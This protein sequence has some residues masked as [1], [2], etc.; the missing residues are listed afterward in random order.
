MASQIETDAGTRHAPEIHSPALNLPPCAGDAT[1]FVARES[2]LADLRRLFARTGEGRGATAL[3]SGDTGIGKTRLALEAGKEAAAR[4][5]QVL[6]GRCY[7]ASEPPP[8]NVFVELIDAALEQAPSL[9]AF[10]DLI[11]A[12]GPELALLVPHLRHTFPEIPAAPELDPIETRRYLF[13]GFSEFVGRLAANRPLVLLLDD[14][15]WADEPTLDLLAHFRGRVDRLPI[16]M[17]AICRDLDPG[18]KSRL[19]A[20]QESWIRQGALPLRIAGLS[21]LGVAELLRSLSGQEAPSSLLRSVYEATRGNP[22]FVEEVFKDLRERKNV[23]DAYGRFLPE[24]GLSEPR[25]PENIRIV[26]TGRISRLSTDTRR[27]LIAAAIFGDTFSFT[28]L[29]ALQQFTSEQ[30]MTAVEE[31]QQAALMVTSSEDGDSMTFAHGLI[32]QTLLAELSSPRRERLHLTAAEALERTYAGSQDEHVSEIANHL[33]KAGAGQEK[34]LVPYLI[35]TGEQYLRLAGY[36]EAIRSLSNAMELNERHHTLT[37][38]QQLANARSLLGLAYMGVGDLG[39]SVRQYELSLDL[40]DYSIPSGRSAAI[41]GVIAQIGIQAARRWWPRV[42]SIDPRARE[43]T[44]LAAANYER[45]TQFSYHQND[46]VRSIFCLLRSLNLAEKTRLT[47]QT[48]RSLAGIPLAA[49]FMSMSGLAE[50]YMSLA[51][52]SKARTRKPQDHA[53]VD[54]YLGMY[55][56]GSGRDWDEAVELFKEASELFSRVGDR[57]RHLESL[58]LLSIA[59]LHSGRLSQAM[60]TRKQVFELA[61]QQGDLQM[62]AMALIELAEAAMRYSQ[63]R[64]A[65]ELLEQ[66]R[67]LEQHTGSVDRIWMYGMLAAARV[68]TGDPKAAAEAAA[69]GWKYLSPSHPPAFYIL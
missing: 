52:A 30:L 68:R 35:K 49:G 48:A 17:I 3:I 4:G 31:A 37:D 26:L 41:V 42:N 23:I 9:P 2:E 44:E 14:L 10:A 6:V 38:R 8:Y 59:M 50:R 7:D 13:D 47:G 51:L 46:P 67:A 19:L 63:I 29:E 20:T 64:R 69:T 66:A 11:G 34:R 39:E 61:C 24:A 56:A 36:S 5:A 12:N 22:F 25:L 21:Q 57:R 65:L 43:I 27:V 40:I 58:S 60:E 53:F 54:E 16:L 62:K 45:L 55:R 18:T 28:E 32:R 1:P 15:Q 33:V